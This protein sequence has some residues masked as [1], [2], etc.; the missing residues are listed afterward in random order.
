MSVEMKWYKKMIN[1]IRIIVKIRKPKELIGHIVEL[2][3]GYPLYTVSFIMPRHKKKW[4]FGT[5]VGFVDNA[6]YLFID[7]SKRKEVDCYWISPKK[8]T[9][10]DIRRKGFQAY[11]KYSI[12]GIWHCLTAY[13]YIFTYHSKDINFWTSAR[14]KK[15]NLWHGVGIKS[16]E[17]GKNN[18]GLNT[19]S[20]LLT[21]FILPHLYEKNTIF[22]STSPLMNAHF[23]KMFSLSNNTIFEGMY[24]RCVFLQK[25]K[26]EVK[27]FID[28]YE[29]HEIKTLISKLETFNR[30]YLYMPTWRGNFKDDFI[31]EAGLDFKALN[32]ILKKKNHLFVLK[33]HPAVK[34]CKETYELFDNVLFLDKQIDIYPIL[35]FTDILITDYSSIYYDYLLME[36]K[37]VILYPFDYEEYIISSNRL[38][39]DFNTYMP[40]VQ[41]KNFKELKNILKDD[42]ASFIIE[43]KTWIINQFWGNHYCKSNEVLYDKIKSL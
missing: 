7:V 4:V 18:K 36:N 43:N 20:N 41:I 32:H 31:A 29:S 28:E 16:G 25:S 8:E 11:Y 1:T 24:P 39:F 37:G 15:V 13:V 27:L 5:N 2:I 22:L 40:G 33:L 17:G 21:K 3:I 10:K 34:Y 26:N 35:P 38:A 14:A 42:N 23:Q 12:K 30:V 9:V 19:N 6:K